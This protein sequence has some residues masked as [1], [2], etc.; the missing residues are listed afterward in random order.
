MQPELS[1]L[2]FFLKDEFTQ[3]QVFKPQYSMR[4]FARDLGLSF[5]SLNEFLSGRRNL[6]LKNLDKI[7]QYL[8]RKSPAV[9]T[10]CG[11]SKHKAGVLIG[12]PGAQLICRSCV[13]TCNDIL[14]TGRMMRRA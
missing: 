4:A 8:K 9:C 14:R 3:R 13:E 6:N 2:R 12:G 1:Q 7:F 5:T 11:A 10:W